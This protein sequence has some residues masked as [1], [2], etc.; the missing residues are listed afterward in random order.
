MKSRARCREVKEHKRRSVGNRSVEADCNWLRWVFNWAAKWRMRSGHYL[1]R[2]NPVR[3]FEVPKEKNPQRP[4]A[5]QDRFEAVRAVSDQVM[6]QSRW[7]KRREDRSYLSELLDVANGTGRRLSAI[8]KLRYE[9]L[10]L[11]QGPYGSILWPASTDKSGRETVIPMSPVVRRAIDRIL[12]ER[13]GIGATPRDGMRPS[14]ALGGVPFQG[15]ARQAVAFKAHAPPS[16]SGLRPDFR[17]S[18]TTRGPEQRYR[19]GPPDG[20][21]G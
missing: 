19:S 18:Q 3:G 5:S 7:G 21:A 15:R 11:H 6:M 10:Q 13:P 9:D 14:D 4:V 16:P 17:S 20:L 1:M 2:E 8:C 12:K